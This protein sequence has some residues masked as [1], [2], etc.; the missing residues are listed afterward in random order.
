MYSKIH[1]TPL[2]FHIQQYIKTIITFIQNKNLYR[3]NRSYT[4]CSSFLPSP[5]RK[6]KVIKKKRVRTYRSQCNEIVSK[7]LFR[8]PIFQEIKKI[9]YKIKKEASLSL[10]FNFSFFYS[11][12]QNN[13]SLHSRTN[14]R[15]IFS[16]YHQCFWF[17]IFTMDN[18]RKK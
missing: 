12:I 7:I 16:Q 6:I 9:C 17:M 4:H 1:N 15:S 13:L 2:T 14:I 8:F 18:W 11:K 10:D 3:R 5:R